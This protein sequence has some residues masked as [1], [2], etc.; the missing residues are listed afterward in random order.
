MAIPPI[1]T[2]A[3]AEERHQMLQDFTDLVVYEPDDLLAIWSRHSRLLDAARGVF[4]VADRRYTKSLL[5]GDRDFG[6]TG[7]LRNWMADITLC[8]IQDYRGSREFYYN[9]PIFCDTN[10]VSFC[11]AFLAGRELGANQA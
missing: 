3:F 1:L 6:T 4:V 9:A 2:D 5:P 7:F 11:G 8:L 10:F